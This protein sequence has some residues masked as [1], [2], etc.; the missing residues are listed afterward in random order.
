MASA[1]IVDFKEYGLYVEDITKVSNEALKSLG[2]TIVDAFKAYGFCYL[3]NHGVDEDLILEY[4]KTSKEFFVLPDEEKVKF[5]IRPDYLFGWVKQEGE[6]LNPDRLPAGDLHEAFNYKPL[7]DITWPTVE[8]FE[9]L[10]KMMFQSLSELARRFLDVLSLG[11]DLPRDFFR[12][13]HSLI[14]KDGNCSAVRTLYYKP[15]LSEVKPGQVRL[16]EH[17][18]YGT[19]TFCIQNAGGMEI[20]GPSGVY[21]PLTPVEGAIAV[22]TSTLLQR[23]TSDVIKETVHRILIP[24]DEDRKKRERQ[25]VVYFMQPDNECLIKCIDGSDKYKPITSVQYMYDK[26]NPTKISN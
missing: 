5:T 16:G 20:K 14:G 22:H 26:I 12:N 2:K 25:S 13:A 10:N 9:T 8:N 21:L 1:P 3:K 15:I 11:L 7:A 19:A 18:D 4:L 17:A 6:S 23:W 24:E